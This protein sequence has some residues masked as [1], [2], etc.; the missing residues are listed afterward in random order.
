MSFSHHCARGTDSNLCVSFLVEHVL[1]LYALGLID[2]L[3]SP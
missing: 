3:P 1:S 2:P